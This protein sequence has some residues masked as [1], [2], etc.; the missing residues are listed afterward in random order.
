LE[1]VDVLALGK[2]DD[3][4]VRY[5][6]NLVDDARDTI[7]KFGDFENFVSDDPAPA[8]SGDERVI[9]INK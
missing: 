2:E 5:Y 7:N 3:I 1:S 8:I 6:R 9:L 4:D